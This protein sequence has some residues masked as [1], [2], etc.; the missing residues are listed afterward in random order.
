MDDDT[1][2]EDDHHGDVNA[3]ERVELLV[4]DVGNLD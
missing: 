3:G 1:D 2:N 4:R